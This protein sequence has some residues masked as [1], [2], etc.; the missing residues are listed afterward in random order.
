MKRFGILIFAA[1]LVFLTASFG[2]NGPTKPVGAPD[3]GPGI[4]PD[5]MPG[6][7]PVPKAIKENAEFQQWTTDFQT[8]RATFKT[9]LMELRRALQNAEEGE[10]DGIRDQIREQMKLH[11]AEQN[12]FRKRVRALMK[13]VREAKVNELSDSE[14]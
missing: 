14:E 13:D 7:P 4:G 3:R 1:L 12:A 11:R 9:R 5:R 8:A 10:R 6:R 2:Q